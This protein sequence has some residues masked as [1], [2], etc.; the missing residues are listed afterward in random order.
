MAEP[1]TTIN[2]HSLKDYE[3]ITARVYALRPAYNR[4]L[5]NIVGTIGEH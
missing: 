2:N 3:L 1:L 4:Q 5:K